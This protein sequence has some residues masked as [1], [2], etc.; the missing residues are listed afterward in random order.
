[1]KKLTCSILLLISTSIP[2]NCTRRDVQPAC[3]EGVVIGV[4]C[5]YSAGFAGHAIRLQQKNLGAVRYI[6][7]LTQEEYKFAV[8]ATNL[9]SK[10]AKPGQRIY[11]IARKATN[12]EAAAMGIIDAFCGT[13]PLVTIIT[14]SD[15]PCQVSDI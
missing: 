12:E 1:M 11:F 4:T 6:N 3:L 15:K 2:F 9:E 5:P 7:P 14:L 13:L 10:Y 8:S